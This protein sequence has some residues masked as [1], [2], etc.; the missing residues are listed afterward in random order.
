MPIRI[1]HSLGC[2][3]HLIAPDGGRKSNSFIGLSFNNFKIDKS[4]PFLSKAK[5]KLKIQAEFSPSPSET[6]RIISNN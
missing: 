2:K 3:L 6:M 5:K 1:G 4:I